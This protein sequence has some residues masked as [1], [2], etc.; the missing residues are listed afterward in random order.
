VVIRPR[1]TNRYYSTIPR[2]NYT[3]GY[4][5]LGWGYYDPFWWGPDL[6]AGYYGGSIYGGPGYGGSIYNYSYD[7]GR[8]RL[9]VEPRDAEVYIDGDY[10][11]LV[12]DFDGRLQGIT[13]ETGGY[14][15]EIVAP[16]L[17][18]LAFDVRITPGRTTTYRGTLLPRR[19]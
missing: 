19:P 8:L 10:V 13:L 12:D 4:G 17:E 3:Y 11:G 14:S 5:G 15:I 7:F 18:P 9:D 1:V 16:G 2:Y 6:R